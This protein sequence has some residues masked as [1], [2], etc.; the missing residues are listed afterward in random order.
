MMACRVRRVGT[1]HYVSDSPLPSTVLI[2]VAFDVGDGDA[3][4]AAA[5]HT[6][7][8]NTTPRCA[9]RSVMRMWRGAEI[10]CCCAFSPRSV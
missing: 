7:A 8:R 4:L 9:S 5:L 3:V 2:L 6:Q 10:L 1:L